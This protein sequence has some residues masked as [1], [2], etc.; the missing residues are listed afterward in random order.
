MFSIPALCV[1]VNFVCLYTSYEI[2]PA[3][4]IGFRPAARNMALIFG[5]LSFRPSKFRHVF[6][7]LYETTL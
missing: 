5:R 3:E 7:K 2:G 4:S 1:R 6:H